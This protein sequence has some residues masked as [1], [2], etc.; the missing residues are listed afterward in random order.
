MLQAIRLPALFA[1]LWLTGMYLRLPMLAAPPLASDMALALR[2]NALQQGMLTTLPLIMLAIGAV[3]GSVLI[4]K[5]GARPALVISLVFIALFSA[6]RGLAPNGALL[7]LAT[8]GMGFGVAMMQPALPALLPAWLNS[9]HLAM[10]T[11]IY[12][13]GMLIGEFTGAGLTIPLL[14]PLLE[15]SWRATIVVWS[16]PA[17]LIALLL[18]LPKGQPKPVNTSS[19]MPNWRSPL[20]WQMGFLMSTSSTLFFGAN[21]YMAPVL[22]A[23]GEA[24]WLAA[25]LFWFNLFQVVASVL[26]IRMAKRWVGLRAPLIFAAVLGLSGMIVFIQAAGLTALFGLLMVSFASAFLLILLVA[27]PPMISR[28]QAGAISAGAF[29]IGYAMSFFV[30]L[31]GG[32]IAQTS[33]SINLAIWTLIAYATIAV[34]L[35]V[36]M[37]KNQ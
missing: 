22:E 37:P 18:L 21:A 24:D 11:A 7:L 23:R 4:Q 31:I 6:A 14:M 19:W 26:L 30:P 1:L 33:G 36:K 10:G 2:L 28:E 3:P 32:W 9:K 20:I 16:L 35:A 15:Q 12:M 29:T 25:S 5:L 13:N 8:A 27:L 34:P 17:I